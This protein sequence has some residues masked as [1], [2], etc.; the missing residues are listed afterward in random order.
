MTYPTAY[1]VTSPWM[2]GPRGQ[3]PVT[4]QPARVHYPAPP[5][6]PVTW[7]G[8]R[9]AG[10]P[11]AAVPA[12]RAASAATGNPAYV[13]ALALLVTVLLIGIPLACYLGQA[14]A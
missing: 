7:P 4:A 8:L 11:V 13:A 9:H 5:Q 12:P 10:V 6:H 14:A 3:T 1:P 2:A